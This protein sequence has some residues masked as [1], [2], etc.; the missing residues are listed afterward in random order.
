MV[1]STC[2]YL[3]CNTKKNSN[4]SLFRFP[5]DKES[6]FIWCDNCGRPELKKNFVPNIPKKR[7]KY[8]VCEKHFHTSDFIISR[9]KKLVKQKAKPLPRF[10]TSTRKEF[11]EESWLEQNMKNEPYLNVLSFSNGNEDRNIKDNVSGL[12]VTVNLSNSNIDTLYSIS[13][14][15]K[16][17][18]PTTLYL[19][20][21]NLKDLDNVMQFE[22]LTHL[23]LVNNQIGT[24]T[25][26]TNLKNLEILNL[27]KNK[28]FCFY[29][30]ISLSKLKELTLSENLIERVPIFPPSFT[31][32]NRL[33][34]LDLS[35]NK[36]KGF[37]NFSQ[38]KRLKELLLHKNMI[39]WPHPWKNV[40]TCVLPSFLTKLTL[41]YNAFSDLLDLKGLKFY[42]YLRELTIVG[43]PCVGSL[44]VLD[45]NGKQL[46]NIRETNF[47]PYILTCCPNLNLLDD[48]PVEDKDREKS[49]WLLRQDMFLPKPLPPTHGDL[50]LYLAE[51]CPLE[52]QELDQNDR[53]I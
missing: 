10:E 22:R 31:D 2:A 11:L 23:S 13:N 37:L 52:P 1:V 21:N 43:N 15:S 8:F 14:W 42:K 3:F 19:D 20:N 6:F 50:V 49:L 36:L 9:T 24:L 12:E 46:G 32:E 38:F 27:S 30:I 53:I 45:A 48:K 26:C 44:L 40:F 39:T 34:K 4:L 28:I 35:W 18:R 16:V 7:Q 25:W 51:N 47:R 41:A 29:G 33:E 17:L 5:T